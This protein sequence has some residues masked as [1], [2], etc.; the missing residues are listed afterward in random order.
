[1]QTAQ[2]SWVHSSDCVPPHENSDTISITAHS[3]KR[4]LLCLPVDLAEFVLEAVVYG[5]YKRK[6]IFIYTAIRFYMQSQRLG[7]VTEK[8]CS[9]P[10]Q[11]LDRQ[12]ST[13]RPAQK[14]KR[15]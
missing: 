3:E 12:R 4:I 6:Q 10:M 15:A 11:V 5:G 13:M 2:N 14:I 8:R 7:V 1:M 9:L